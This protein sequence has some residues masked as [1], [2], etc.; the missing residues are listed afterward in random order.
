MDQVYLAYGNSII[1]NRLQH[2]G[3]DNFADHPPSPL[4]I[5]VLFQNVCFHG[6]DFNY[7]KDNLTLITSAKFLYRF[8]IDWMNVVENKIL[9]LKNVI[10]MLRLPWKPI[11]YHVTILNLKYTGHFLRIPSFM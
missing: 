2:F 6:F 5:A 8:C 10:S 7:L 9:T 4:I 1:P 11:R 3:V